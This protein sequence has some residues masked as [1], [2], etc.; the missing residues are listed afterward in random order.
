MLVWNDQ[1]DPHIH[2][3]ESFHFIIWRRFSRLLCFY[4]MVHSKACNYISRIRLVWEL[5]VR[6]GRSERLAYGEPLWL[7]LIQEVWISWELFMDRIEEL[8]WRLLG[9]DM[10]IVILFS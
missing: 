3:C 7:C 5:M 4:S 1:S 2:I 6:H 10:I 8:E 9:T